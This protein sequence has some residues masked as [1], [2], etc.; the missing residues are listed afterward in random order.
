M[1]WSEN[2]WQRK[3]EYNRRAKKAVK[4]NSACVGV[5]RRDIQT[6]RQTENERE[7]EREEKTGKEFSLRE[8]QLTTLEPFVL[9][10]SYFLELLPGAEGA[11]YFKRFDSSDWFLIYI[12]NTSIGC[13]CSFC[14][15][16][17]STV[18]RSVCLMLGESR[19]AMTAI[20]IHIIGTYVNRSDKYCAEL[21]QILFENE[22]KNFRVCLILSLRFFS[23]FLWY[24]FLHTNGI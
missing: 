11:I 20:F 3:C 16:I 5:T 10:P 8:C 17:N 13:I 12:Y 6:G 1:S 4:E 22:Y 18:P 14:D 21:Q 24:F 2:I 7:G 9:S 15:S 23:V 19:V